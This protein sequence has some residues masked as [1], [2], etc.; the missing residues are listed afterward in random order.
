MTATALVD[1]A[2]PLR[3]VFAGADVCL[4]A[5]LALPDRVRRPMFDHDLWDFTEVVGLPN[6]MARVS[7]R[8][9]FAAIVD[10][11]WRLVAKELILAMLTPRHQAVAPLP[12]AYRTP[13]HLNTARGRLAELTRF[14]NWLTGQG[15]ASLAEVDSERC[16]HYLAHRR[17]VRDQ[18]DAVVGQRSPATR[19]AAAQTSWTW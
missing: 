7:R 2:G 14:L 15:V 18:N 5:G 19:R 10:E 17:Y 16:E 11:R 9:D 13:L 6:Q 12:R 1:A 4:E 3:S 8:F